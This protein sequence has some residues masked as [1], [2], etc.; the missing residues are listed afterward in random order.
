VSSPTGSVPARKSPGGA[1]ISALP[2]GLVLSVTSTANDARGETFARA[3]VLVRKRRTVVWV[4]YNYLVCGGAPA[5]NPTPA[6]TPVP[7][8][9]TP[10]PPAPARQQIVFV[11]D[12]KRLPDSIM[13]GF[14]TE[15]GSVSGTT[16]TRSIQAAPYDRGLSFL[17][18]DLGRRGLRLSGVLG[19]RDDAQ[20]DVSLRVEMFV[21][22]NRVFDQ[23]TGLGRV[24]PIDVDITGGLRLRIQVT[25]L[26]KRRQDNYAVLGDLR[27]TV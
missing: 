3:V 24:T 22:G 23:T 12:L 6:P 19:V 26:D 7:P 17:E 5:P 11:A 2:N 13:N 27:Y 15:P 21:D 10:T 8:A 20:S 18:Y 4:Y 14:N 25:E 16:Y 1:K 9:P